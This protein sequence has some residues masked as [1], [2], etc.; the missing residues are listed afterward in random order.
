MLQ[1]GDI[2]PVGSI[3]E[4]LKGITDKGALHAEV[5][6]VQEET[7]SVEGC[8]GTFIR[9]QS[10]RKYGVARVLT[11]RGWGIE[12][13]D[14]ISPEGLQK[15]LDRAVFAAT[16]CGYAKL[17][18][19][20]S[21]IFDWGAGQG[22]FVIPERL[23]PTSLSPSDFADFLSKIRALAIDVL[24]TYYLSSRTRMT[25][26]KISKRV[27]GSDGTD[28][29][30][31]RPFS[32]V[33]FEVNVKVPRRKVLGMGFRVGSVGGM[34]VMFS[35]IIEQLV[36]N[37][38]G[39]ARHLTGARVLNP[40]WRG[41][42]LP[43]VL[44][45]DLSAMAIYKI[46]LEKFTSDSIFVSGQQPTE[47]I[48][49]RVASEE[50]TIFDDPM[51]SNGYGSYA[52][53]DEGVRTRRKKIMEDGYL[54]TI[55]NTKLHATLMGEEPTGNGRGLRSVPHAIPGNV[56][57]RS[58]DWSLEELIEGVDLGFYLHGVRGVEIEGG[59]ITIKPQIAFLI[60]KG[61]IKIAVRDLTVSE[62]ISKF[63]NGINGIGKKVRLYAH[64]EGDIP[65][66]VGAPPLRISQM[67]IF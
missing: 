43:V 33:E 64:T 35:G 6:L 23:P 25:Y 26:R 29:Y 22:S 20:S 38:A 4:V 46:L 17:H 11:K 1:T 49:T 42:R 47:L 56:Y 8:D 58:K 57:V 45:C 62:E 37:C 50:L 28:I 30:E 55:I 52:F 40:L 59:R 41:R 67:H 48:G 2:S 18:Q 27:L 5:V 51:L 10:R 9:E 54:V 24:G 36:N 31:E 19:L 16:L 63:L 53:D 61:E 21:K 65:V 12:V 15:A 14:D 39:I 44:D 66:G 60:E 34:E 32:G 7:F 3:H 13:T